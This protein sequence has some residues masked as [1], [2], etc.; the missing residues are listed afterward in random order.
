VKTDDMIRLLGEDQGSRH[1]F[2]SPGNWLLLI[3]AAAIAAGLLFLALFG[4]RD[5]FDTPAIQ[6]AVAFK[7]LFSVSFAIGGL[8]LLRR[9]R[10]PLTSRLWPLLVIA[11]L[12]LLAL[13]ITLDASSSSAVPMSSRL[14]GEHP[15]LCL[16]YVPLFS[17]P[18][19]AMLFHAMRQDAPAN[20]QLTGAFVGLSAAAI[21][22]SFYGLGCT[23]DSPLFVLT[24]YTLAAL[25]VTAIGAFAGRR[26]LQW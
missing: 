14:I 20:P 2:V 21:S 24:W 11:F 1:P 25:I 4:P 13:G 23:N 9:M 8:W 19:F 7:L 18:P 5:S 3:L 6:Q 22:A 15:W 12:L 26:W 10:S 16:L 17:I